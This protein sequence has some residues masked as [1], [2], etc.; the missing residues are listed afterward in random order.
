ML[1]AWKQCWA[2]VMSC[3]YRR[4]GKSCF[5]HLQS[6]ASVQYRVAAAVVHKNIIKSA[7]LPNKASIFRAELYAISLAMTLIRCSKEEFY[8]LL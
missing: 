4:T 3:T 6:A 2:L 8:C 7:R 5:S 1:V